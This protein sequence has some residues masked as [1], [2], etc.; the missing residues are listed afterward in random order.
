MVKL[1]V[2]HCSMLIDVAVITNMLL[3]PQT[4]IIPAFECPFCRKKI[5]NMTFLPQ[6]LNEQF[7]DERVN[8]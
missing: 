6:D 8:Y 3:A 4:L 5:M 7:Y 2:K 1:K